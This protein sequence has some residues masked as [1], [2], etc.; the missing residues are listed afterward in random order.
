MI[1][2]LLKI[3]EIVKSKICSLC[4]HFWDSKTAQCLLQM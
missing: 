3:D 4:E 1:Q 2:K